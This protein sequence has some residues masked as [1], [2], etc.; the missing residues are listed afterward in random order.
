MTY[1][2]KNKRKSNKKILQKNEQTLRNT[3]YSDEIKE[4]AKNLLSKKNDIN[5]IIECTNLSKEEIENL[6]KF[7]RFFCY[8]IKEN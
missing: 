1:Q 8:F 2:E 4:T 7:F 3:R 5:T 6:N